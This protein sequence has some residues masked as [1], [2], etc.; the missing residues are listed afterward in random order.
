MDL[1]EFFIDII[2]TRGV[3]FRVVLGVRENI[4]G[5]PMIERGK[6]VAFYDRRFAFT[7]HGQFVS[8]YNPMTLLDRDA[9]YGLNLQGGVSD[10]MIDYDNMRIIDLWLE[11]L[12]N[13]F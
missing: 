13:H 3:P 10:W 6:V 8:D 7:Q 9:D 2:N 4:H 11:M 1:E 12:V 5:E